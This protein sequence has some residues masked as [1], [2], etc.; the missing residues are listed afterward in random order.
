MR[1][2]GFGK[3]V[4]CAVVAALCVAAGSAPRAEKRGEPA[5]T[6]F[7]ARA[8][9]GGERG[10]GSRI[11]IIIERWSS[12]AERDEMR[13]A[14]TTKGAGSLLA[15]LHG[16]GRPAGVMLIPG[17]PAAGARARLRHPINLYFARQITTPTGRQIVA[18][19]DHY[20]ALD[21]PTVKWPSEVEFSLLDIR[22][23][24]GGTGVGKVAAGAELAY[25]SKTRTIEVGNYATRPARLIE[26]RPA[27]TAA[28]PL[29]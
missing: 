25:N 10:E 1:N 20:L 18:A 21:E 5:F 6:H 9:V 19:T 28:T 11:D 22:F 4:V 14:F 2:P 29:K 12:D 8:P 7:V 13:T 3:S 15:T 16:I 26:V 24:A 23:T 17:V 27:P